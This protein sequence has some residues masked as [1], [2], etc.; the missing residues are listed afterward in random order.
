MPEN[1]ILLFPVATVSARAGLPSD[2]PP[3]P[4]R[5]SHGRQRQ[6]LAGKFSAL[7]QRFGDI[8]ADI[9]GVD[10]EQVIVFETVGSLADFQSVVKRIAGMEWLGDFDTDITDPDPG[11]LGDG[12]DATHL[13]GRLF[14]VVSNRT[15]YRE[16]LRLW[17]EWSHAQDEKLPHGY[18]KLADVLKHLQDLRPWGP[19][20]RIA[21]TGV[22]AYWEKGLSANQPN[23]RFEAELWCR[24][25]GASRDRAYGRLRTVVE[26]VGG[27]CVKQSAIPDIDYHGV[28]LQVPAQAVR[29]TVEALAA[30]SDTKLLRL[31]DVK[32]FA[33][34][35][36]ASVAPAPDGAPQPPVQ[37]PLPVAD[38]V[39]AIF[40]GLPL[41]NHAALIGR[42]L[43]DDPDDFASSYQVGEHRHGTAMASLVVHGELDANEPA[44]ESRVY[45]RPVMY[46]GPPDVNNRRWEAFPPD[47]LP[48]DLIHRAVRRLF[49]GDGDQPPRAPSVK[50]I[51]LSLGDASQLFDR[52]VS[53]WARLL[54]W[55]A[56]KYNVLFVVSGG[57][58]L[59][60][61]SLPAPP[62]SIAAMSDD[63][64]RGH[65]LRS[66]AHQRVQR[67]LLAPAESV[68]SL[69]VGA[70]HAQTGPIGPSGALVDLLR[71]APLPSPVSTVASGFRRAVKPEILVPGGR[72]HYTPRIQPNGATT[73]EFTI[74]NA[75]AQPGQLVATPGGTAVPP[76]HATRVSGTSNAAA[77]TT[78]R[79]VQFVQR[80]E[81][82]R[83]EPGGAM[84]TDARMAVILKAM[85]VHGA[86]WGDW[87]QF[88][89]Q[90][91]DGPDDGAKRW[92][93]IKSACAQMLGYGT[94]DFDRGTLCTGQRVII[95]G[96]SE[97]EAEQG[98][99]YQVP[100][101]PA[102]SAQTVRRRLAVTLAWLTPVNTRHR[103]YATADLWF[104]PPETHLQ[105]KRSDVDYRMVKR[106]TVQHEVLE[107]NAA[108]P[109]TENDTMPIQVNCRADAASKLVAPV[110]Y[111]LIVSLE[112]AQPLGV[113]IYDQVK[114]ALDR[115]RGA[116]RVRPAVQAA[117]PR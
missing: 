108:V 49:E 83:N 47:E 101:P 111:A 5:P 106:G 54:D 113:S 24:T 20:D 27:Q 45:V 94:A 14:V 46:P 44:L 34:M 18:G 35:G 28:L 37:R 85:L 19:K 16:L 73:A 107:G 48:V 52:V 58:H 74:V 77:L 21:A 32:Y 81:E 115:I 104:D 62:G 1:P 110:P 97:L 88:I 66:M 109:I 78:R 92:W 7:Q 10:P 100:L 116:A 114:V 96:C 95:L 53:P 87:E 72:R 84:L 82:L 90:V 64:L 40:D 61:L 105:V 51:N 56:H 13:P 22:V 59:D 103:N 41:T 57:N 23:I 38:P 89:D 91:F 31:T 93:R 15:A 76:S 69:T 4:P 60:D 75:T 6:R 2:I 9:G 65:T 29:Q 11:F 99:L 8:Q 55:L 112:T 33:P 42:L 30:G 43:V 79:A 71:A 12:S 3:K 26:E 98:H 17:R 70:L 67:R 50:V 86:S 102:L 68:N 25:D 80:I 63:D 36:Q 39:A 117:R